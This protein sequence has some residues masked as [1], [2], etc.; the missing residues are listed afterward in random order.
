MPSNGLIPE[1]FSTYGMVDS[2]GTNADIFED[3]GG[4]KGEPLD[5]HLIRCISMGANRLLTMP[6]QI[7]QLVYPLDYAGDAYQTAMSVSSGGTSIIVPRATVPKKPG[8]NVCDVK[9]R[10]IVTSGITLHIFVATK[11]NQ[12]VT[13]TGGDN[14]I[15]LAGTGALQSGT[16]TGLDID[17]GP[18]EEFTIV[19]RADIDTTAIATDGT[20]GVPRDAADQLGSAG[21]PFQF[22]NWLVNMFTLGSGQRTHVSAN[23]IYESGGTWSSP[24]DNGKFAIWFTDSTGNGLFAP[25]IIVNNPRHTGTVIEFWPPLATWERN[26]SEDAGRYAFI[27]D[28]PTAQIGNIC[29]AARYED[30][31]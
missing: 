28:A 18:Y 30:P 12:N 22:D 24:I 15:S 29:I 17:P 9:V 1:I 2:S 13:D 8:M 19:T 7:L 14:V 5:Q 6:E 10:A 4:D 31:S 25:R 27:L 26:A 11:D 20:I 3:S 21:D 16:I 23:G